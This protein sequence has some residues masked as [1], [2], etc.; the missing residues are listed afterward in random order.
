MVAALQAEMNDSSKLLRW[1]LHDVLS[2]ERR[3]RISDDLD[4]ARW[5]RCERRGERCAVTA[6][7]NSS[8]TPLAREHHGDEH[9]EPLNADATAKLPTAAFV[10]VSRACRGMCAC[11][12]VSA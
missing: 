2:A 6:L 3:C 10:A 5:Q 12:R 1:S 11:V 9:L 8:Y 7:G 4:H